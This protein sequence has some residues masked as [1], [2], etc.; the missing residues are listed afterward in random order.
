M[1][2]SFSF[3]LRLALGLILLGGSAATSPGR[4]SRSLATLWHA[5]D[6]RLA[7]AWQQVL[8]GSFTAERA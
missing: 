4:P 6:Q 3:F 8:A 2:P 7:A 1:K 5:A